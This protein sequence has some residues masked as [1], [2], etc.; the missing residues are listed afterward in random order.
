[1][2]ERARRV[3][4]ASDGQA[5]PLHGGH[6][7]GFQRVAAKGELQVDVYR[8]LPRADALDGLAELAAGRAHGKIVIDL[9]L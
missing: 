1:V 9:S 3:D 5:D 8:V 2:H 7:G 4:A 6:V